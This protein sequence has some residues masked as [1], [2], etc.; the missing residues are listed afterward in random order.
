MASDASP[1]VIG[2]VEEG[3]MA[4]PSNEQVVRRYVAATGEHDFET[5]GR[6]RGPDWVQEFPQTGERVRG[7]Q[8]ARA[9]I[10]NW[11]G[12]RPSPEPVHIVGSEDRWVA[13]P[14]NTIQRVVGSGDLWWADGTNGYPD[15][16]TWFVAVLFQLRD[17]MIHRET[18]YFGAPLE[19]PAWRAA[20]V[21]P[22]T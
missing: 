9:I 20:W 17:S 5:L 6:L 12:G 19:A 18:W 1:D 16:S 4:Q 3:R 10:E 2:I 13:T 22:I 21:E 11:P 14:A 8:N 15:G 7:H